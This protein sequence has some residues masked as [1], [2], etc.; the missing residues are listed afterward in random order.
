[1]KSPS[2]RIPDK[3][4]PYYELEGPIQP[5]D[6]TVSAKALFMTVRRPSTRSAEK[7]CG[8]RQS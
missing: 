6:A 7:S 1:M 8:I 4:G 2:L 5:V 3:H